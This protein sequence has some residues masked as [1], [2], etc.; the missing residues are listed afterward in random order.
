MWG[1]VVKLRVPFRVWD[2]LGG[3]TIEGQERLQCFLA[4][5]QGAFKFRFARQ[6]FPAPFELQGRDPVGEAAHVDD[7][8][9]RFAF[10]DAHRGGVSSAFQLAVVLPQSVV[11]VHGRAD[12]GGA[13]GRRFQQIHKTGS[14]F[15]GWWWWCCWWCFRILIH[16]FNFNLL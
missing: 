16:L 7:P 9:P 12:V 2:G 3:G 11:H 14:C 15:G 1:F 8:P 6:L 4:S 5:L 10:L 13:A